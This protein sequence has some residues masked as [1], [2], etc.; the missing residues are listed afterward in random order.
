MSALSRLLALALAV[1]V[2]A[3]SARHDDSSGTA[4]E[5]RVVVATFNDHF[6]DARIHAVY[7][8]G[9]RQ[10]LGTIAGNGGKSEVEIGWEP[11][12]LVFH[13]DFIISNEEYVTWPIDVNRGQHIELRL[14]P[15][16]GASGYFRRVLD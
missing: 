6:Y 4:A 10:T 9:K 3:C 7:G 12:G 15:N 16:I 11:S 5:E 14:P 2:A 8:G 1:V 13:I